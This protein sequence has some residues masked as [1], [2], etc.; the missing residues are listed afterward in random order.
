MRVELTRSKMRT[1][2]LPYRKRLKRADARRLQEDSK[3]F[4]LGGERAFKPFEEEEKLMHTAAAKDLESAERLRTWLLHPDE[5]VL[6]LLLSSFYHWFQQ[7]RKSWHA[8][9]KW[10][11]SQLM[12]RIFTNGEHAEEAWNPLRDKAVQVDF[13]ATQQEAKYFLAALKNWLEEHGTEEVAR[14]IVDSFEN[15]KVVEAA[16]RHTPGL[17]ENFI[18]E[19]ATRFRGST[20]HLGALAENE[21]LSEKSAR[22]LGLT[23]QKSWLEG[24]KR[25][26]L[27]GEELVGL[28][29]LSKQGHG[30]GEFYGPILQL[31]LEEKK[32][33]RLGE[34]IKGVAQS[35]LQWLYERI[36]EEEPDLP[37]EVELKLIENTPTDWDG[38]SHFLESRNPLTL[39]PEVVKALCQ[40]SKSTNLRKFIARSETLRDVPSLR[41]E[42]LSS[43]SVSVMAAVIAWGEK[44]LAW[45][46]IPLVFEK[47]PEEILEVLSSLP[48]DFIPPLDE[49]VVTRVLK[50]APRETRLKLMTILGNTTLSLRSQ[51]E[52]RKRNE[53]A[54]RQSARSSGRK[55]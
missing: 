25:G 2:R 7:D 31:L 15:Y 18:K 35:R 48:E 10:P 54:R 24:F 32:D 42:A 40:K 5:R 30:M 44:D 22:L 41:E 20:I 39:K 26:D 51:G 19:M 38:I 16:L 11:K 46:R 9:K 28:T 14:D 50:N 21:H 36:L 4:G 43:N 8:E 53:N 33:T 47:A 3:L 55:L 37:L 6:D 49:E 1:A 45:E 12:G 17:S 52:S 27:S 13:V 29:L 34:R 23:L